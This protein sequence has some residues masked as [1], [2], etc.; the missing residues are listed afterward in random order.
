MNEVIVGVCEFVMV[1][2]VLWYL[3]GVF[4]GYGS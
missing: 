1:I 4:V 2:M 3:I